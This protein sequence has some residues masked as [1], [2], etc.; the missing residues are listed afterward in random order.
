MNEVITWLWLVVD[1]LIAL[2]TQ[3]FYYIAI[4][5]LALSYRRQGMLERRLLHT[6]LNGWPLLTLRAIFTGILVGLIV[7]VVYVLLGIEMTAQAVLAIWVTSI[8]LMLFRIRYLNAVYAVGLLGIVQWLLKLFDSWEPQGFLEAIVSAIRDLPIPQLL[9][10]AAVLHLTQAMFVRLQQEQNASPVYFKGKRGKLVGGYQ[11]Q[12]Y[13]PVPLMLLVPTTSGSGAGLA[14]S[15]L[16]AGGADMYMLY[17]VPFIIG[18][19]EMTKS[20]LPEDKSALTTKRLLLY[21]VILLV[22]SLLS[23]WWNP[24]SL[25][26]V[27]FALIG[28]EAICWIS[29]LEEEN[30]SPI[31]VHPKQGLQ[32]LA[33]LPGSPAEELGI[34]AGEVIFRVNGQH[35]NSQAELHSALRMN[36]AFC[37]LEVRNIEGESKFLQRAIYEGEHHQLGALLAPDPDSGFAIDERPASFF[38]IVGMKLDTHR[39]EKP[40]PDPFSHEA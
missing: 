33:V 35:I 30:R 12:Y 7:S 5:L 28:L 25:V 22:L 19:S 13:V 15:P 34:Q 17:A 40:A 27:L 9:V 10:L 24:V 6:R 21:G 26:A 18:F 4:V 38:Q 1:A 31:Y 11:L 36:P 14:W 8:I 2:L 32:V 20:M 23:V 37:K 16:L 39:T 3:P 29:S